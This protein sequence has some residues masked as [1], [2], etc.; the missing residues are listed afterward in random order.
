MSASQT[1]DYDY[2]YSLAP[3]A[4]HEAFT[5][6]E[7]LGFRAHHEPGE[8][9]RT[10]TR[11]SALAC[12]IHPCSRLSDRAGDVIRRRGPWD[13]PLTLPSPLPLRFWWDHLSR[14]RVG[15]PGQEPPRPFLPLPRD[16]QQF[17]RSGV[18]SID[19]GHFALVRLTLHLGIGS[20]VPRV[21]FWPTL[22]RGG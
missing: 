16:Q 9:V 11:V 21:G 20:S 10:H 13:R 8:G 19:R 1:L 3:G 18:S 4:V 6:R 12:P 14:L 2:P 22:M 15:P 17:L 7:V 5:S